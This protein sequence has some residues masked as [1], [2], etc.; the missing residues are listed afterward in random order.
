MGSRWGKIN[1]STDSGC[2][3]GEKPRSCFEIIFPHL[4]QVARLEKA[5][6]AKILAVKRI[7]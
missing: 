1:L 7:P 4:L 5:G 6:N 2:S 3:P